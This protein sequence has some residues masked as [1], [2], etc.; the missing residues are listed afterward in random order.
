MRHIWIVL[1]CAALAP[2]TAL[3]QSAG[4]VERCFQSPAAC[5]QG[6]GAAAPA[7]SAT[8][9]VAA[10]RPAAPAPDYTTVLQSP[11]ADHT[12]THQSLPPPATSNPPIP[13][14]PPPHAP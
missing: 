13:P 2:A 8:P 10:T 1:A 6:G 12:R 5:G 11:D 7:P 14:H 4:E 9:P 3:G